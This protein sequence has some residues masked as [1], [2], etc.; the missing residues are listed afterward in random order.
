[1]LEL[2]D[3]REHTFICGVKIKGS[4][5]SKVI[6]RL[7]IS[8]GEKNIFFEGILKGEECHIT[9]PPM[10]NI[11]EKGRVSLE[12]IIDNVL[13]TP[14]DSKYI[15]VSSYKIATIE[16]KI[17]EK[18]S[19]RQEDLTSAAELI[20]ENK[21]EIVKV[22][23]LVK[24]THA[25]KKII[26][27]KKFLKENISK[28]S[29]VL[30]NNLLGLYNTL[31]KKEKVLIFEVVRDYTPKKKTFVWAKGAFKKPSSFIAKIC[32]YEIEKY[33]QKKMNVKKD[34]QQIKSSGYE[35]KQK[36]NVD[37]SK[38]N[39]S[40]VQ[41]KKK[42]TEEMSKKKQTEE[43]S[44]YRKL[45]MDNQNMDN[46]NVATI[47][48]ISSPQDKKKKRMSKYRKLILMNT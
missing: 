23:E 11:D 31:P 29:K 34:I 4:K 8:S 18:D 9:I 22:K 10:S 17:N 45:I 38:S 21:K 5:Y 41:K 48:E 46:Q 14:W 32:M 33:V 43:M 24:E 35:S 44:P 42:Q 28:K 12:L 6:P 36:K 30:I 13:M 39:T 37:I 3:D 19:E 7:V 20:E 25:Q 1:M 15:L 40:Y 2:Y 27:N 26:K 47:I 16:P